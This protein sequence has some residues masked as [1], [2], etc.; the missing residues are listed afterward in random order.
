MSSK[1]PWAPSKS[2]KFFLYPASLINFQTGV[3]KVFKYPDIELRS[4]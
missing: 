3:E 2:I 4:L 1:E